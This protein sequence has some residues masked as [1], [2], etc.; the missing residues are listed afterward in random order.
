MH[1]TPAL[2]PL[3]NVLPSWQVQGHSKPSSSQG[4]VRKPARPSSWEGGGRAGEQ[5]LMQT[6]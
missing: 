3:P 4:Q 2:L 1:K 6:S 5:E